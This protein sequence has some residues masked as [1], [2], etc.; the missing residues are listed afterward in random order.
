MARVSL[1]SLIVAHI[2]AVVA[3]AAPLPAEDVIGGALAEHLK[4]L[5]A[6]DVAL[7]DFEA[8]YDTTNSSPEA[9]EQTG[10]LVVA[11]RGD[12]IAIRV[13]TNYEGWPAP[14]SETHIF[15]GD[16]QS[17]I[18]CGATLKRAVQEVPCH[19]YPPLNTDLGY[20]IGGEGNDVR[21]MTPDEIAASMTSKSVSFTRTPNVAGFEQKSTAFKDQLEGRQL[22]YAFRKRFDPETG[23]FISSERGILIKLDGQDEVFAPLDVMTVDSRESGITQSVTRRTYSFGAMQSIA[24]EGKTNEELLAGIAKHTAA[25]ES[26]QTAKLKC[27][28]P[29]SPETLVS[30][31]DHRALVRTINYS[32]DPNAPGTPVFE[33]SDTCDQGKRLL[34]YDAAKREWVPVMASAK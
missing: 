9:G 30:V 21:M 33:T 8:V 22:A 25:P 23:Q 2:A 34:D 26:Q 15:E 28:N 24:R 1:K 13:M 19:L 5:Q 6:I 18:F 31:A 7:A 11:R 12:A 4:D 14:Y 29:L 16:A 17:M 10:Q 20:G 32:E 27:I 3:F